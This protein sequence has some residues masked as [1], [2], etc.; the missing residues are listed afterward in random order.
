LNNFSNVDAS[1]TKNL[2]TSFT[3]EPGSIFKSIVVSKALDKGCVSAGD[4]F[5]LPPTIKVGDKNIKEP[6]RYQ[7][8]DYS[9]S[10]IL[11]NSSNVGAALMGMKIGKDKLYEAILDFGFGKQTGIDFIGEESGIV[12]DPKDWGSSMIGTLPIGQGIMVTPIQIAVAYSAIANGG[13][14]V[15]PYI[16]QKL[17]NSYGK[18]QKF[19]SDA[20][21]TQVISSNTSRLMTEILTKVIT[22]GTGQMAALNGY[23][24]AGKTGTAQKVDSDGFGYDEGKNIVSFVGF[25]PVQDPEIVIVIIVDEPS[26][27]AGSVWGGT[28]SAPVFKEI[29]EFTLLHLKVQPDE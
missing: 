23:S 13:Y 5:N 22:N 19:G 7:T 16:V 26:S 27:Q 15:K 24:A 11:V 14:L 29:A 17:V 2:G 6:H 1:L 8:V 9:V 12:I 20:E 25:A 4:I 21:T 3:F 28:I 18:E 10:D